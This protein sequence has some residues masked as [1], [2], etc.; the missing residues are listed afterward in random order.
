[1]LRMTTTT[2]PRG[3]PRSFD[4]AAALEQALLAFWERGYDATSVADLTAAMGI[5]APSLYAA[6][7]DKRRL[8]EE[9]VSSYQASHGAFM[10]RALAGEPTAQQA[11]AR[12]LREAA[13]EYTAAGHPHGCLVI[14]AA[15][16]C[17]PASADVEAAL[18]TIRR[19]NVEALQQRIQ[20]DVDAGILPSSTDARALAVLT[21][22][23]FLGMSQQARDGAS[24]AD[25][26]AVAAAVMLAW[27]A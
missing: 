20:A 2:S 13:V 26:Q 21:G 14:S 3:R 17:I 19:G 6:F 23:T 8:F 16:N 15:Q 24:E 1:M 10:A 12:M 5:G 11:V 25:L 18:R 22:A 9:V 4:R 27:P 7:G